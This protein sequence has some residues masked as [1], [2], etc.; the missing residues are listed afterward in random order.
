MKAIINGKKYDTETA[1]FIGNASAYP[2]TFNW[3]DEDLYQKRTGEFFL[4][5]EGNAASK[6]S[7][8]DGNTSLPGSGFIPLTQEKARE[9]CEK[10]LDIESYEI[11]FGEVTE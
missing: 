3:Y 5:G 9:W 10:N 7:R 8:H 6:Y 4:Y 11:I 1:E 2:S